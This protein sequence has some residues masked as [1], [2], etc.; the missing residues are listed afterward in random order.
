MRKLVI[1]EESCKACG[2]C[3]KNCPKEALSLAGQINKAGYI[4][5]LVDTEKC[6]LCGICYNVC[7]DYVYEIIDEKG[8]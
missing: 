3:V 7:P 1:H 4:T 2:Y 5:T 6:I 8:A